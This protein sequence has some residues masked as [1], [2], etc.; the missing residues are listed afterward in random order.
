MKNKF[1]FSLIFA[2]VV[3]TINLAAQ[4]LDIGIFNSPTG[5][6]KLEIRVKPSSDVNNLNY[7]QGVFSIR[8]LTTNNAMLTVLSSV[9]GYSYANLTGVDGVYTYFSYSFNAG[10]FV[11][12][13]AGQEVVIA[14]LQFSTTNPTPSFDVIDT[15]SWTAANNGEYYQVLDG[16]EV[17]KD[18]YQ[19]TTG[20]IVLPVELLSFKADKKADKTLI[21][22]ET[23][24]EK[25]LSN[26][27]IERSDDGRNFKPIGFEKPKAKNET[28]K[29]AYS[30]LDDSPEIGIN[31]YRLQSKGVRKEDFKY[32][33]IVSVDFGLG[34]KAKTF[35]N[36]FA[37]ELN[38]EIDIEQGVKGEVIIDL[39][40][41]SGKQVLTKK[42]N[43]E[44]RKLNFDVPTEGLAPGSYVIRIKNGSYT[45]QHKITKQ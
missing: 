18:P 2:F 5:S 11:T 13:T 36:P 43:A 24:Q 33:K 29:A 1:F 25:N 9:F 30:F 22:W 28:E 14:V 27:I 19:P 21:Q 3:G 23:V 34:I 37:A 6:N 45:W 15:D 26:Y 10:S 31:Y 12:W 8:T 35:P 38:V 39:F 41:T 20:N 32:S 40:D 42:I 7:S 17:Q 44:G 16:L 4:Q